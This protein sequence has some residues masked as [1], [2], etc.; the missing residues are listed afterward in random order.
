MK[1]NLQRMLCNNMKIHHIS[2]TLIKA[3]SFCKS[4]YQISDSR[5]TKFEKMLCGNK[6]I[7]QYQENT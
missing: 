3:L 4:L 6:K 1:A 5:V 7:S 2:K